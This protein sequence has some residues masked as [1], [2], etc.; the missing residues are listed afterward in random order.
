MASTFSSTGNTQRFNTKI[1]M[2][3]CD[4]LRPMRESLRAVKYAIKHHLCF[5]WKISTICAVFEFPKVL[6]RLP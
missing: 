3:E 5:S 2:G 6:M 1:S 4:F